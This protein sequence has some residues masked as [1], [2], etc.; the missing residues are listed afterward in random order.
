MNVEQIKYQVLQQ[1]K[2]K[3]EV[4]E[5]I[6]RKRFCQD[7][8]NSVRYENKI[9]LN[10]HKWNLKICIQ[11]KD[12]NYDSLDLDISYGVLEGKD[13]SSDA[14]VM[15]IE[16][17]PIQEHYSEHEM[18]SDDGLFF[19]LSHNSVH[20]TNDCSLFTKFHDNLGLI[21]YYIEE[22][23]FDDDVESVLRKWR[24]IKL[25]QPY[26]HSLIVTEEILNKLNASFE[27]LKKR[28]PYNHKAINAFEILIKCFD[29]ARFL[30][31]E[32]GLLPIVRM[33]NQKI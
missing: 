23:K 32:A 9:Q 27:R 13:E 16:D 6:M 8:V 26:Y 7:T 25:D 5:F 17:E 15:D 4:I 14:V 24:N 20:S 10:S 11:K 22:G 12:L 30:D 18:I 28:S 33:F 1:F 21:V 31:N 2:V 29:E 19:L 3:S